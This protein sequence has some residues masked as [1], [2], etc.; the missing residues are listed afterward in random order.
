[1]SSTTLLARGNLGPQFRLVPLVPEGRLKS[2]Q[3]AIINDEVN[4]NSIELT[5]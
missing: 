5:P 2:E 3:S 1:M 4:S